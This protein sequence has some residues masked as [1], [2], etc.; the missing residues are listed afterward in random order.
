MS[1]DGNAATTDLLTLAAGNDYRLLRH[2]IWSSVP[3]IGFAVGGVMS[4]ILFT[5]FG[6]FSIILAQE[7]SFT[8][9]RE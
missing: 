8:T 7:V 4:G 6:C 3:W 1:K 5:V 2:E 9:R